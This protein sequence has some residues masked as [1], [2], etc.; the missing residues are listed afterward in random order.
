MA[1][2]SFMGKGKQ[3]ISSPLSWSQHINVNGDTFIFVITF[4]GEH[5]S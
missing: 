3:V 5:F 2:H 4:E 1:F